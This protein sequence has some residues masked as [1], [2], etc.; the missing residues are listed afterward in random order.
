MKPADL[1]VTRF[2]GL[3]TTG[4]PLTMGLSWLTEADNI[5]VT[6][7]D[8]IE[9]RIGHAATA[10][11]AGT[12][13]SSA[14]ATRDQERAYLIDSGALKTADNVTLATGL[15]TDQA[16]WAEVNDL[17]FMANGTDAVMIDADN[18]VHQWAWPVPPSPT[19]AAVS[20]TLAAGLYRACTTYILPDGRE[21][22]PSEMVEIELIEGQALQVSGIPQVSGYITRTYICPANSTVFGLARS[23]SVTAFSW[24]HPPTSLGLELRTEGCDPIPAGCDVIQHWQGRIWA[25]LY[26]P[27][28]DTTAIFPSKP[29]GFHL[30]D[31]DEA[32]AVTGCVLMLAPTDAGL[33]IGTNKHI[34][35]RL[36]DGQLTRIAHYGVVPGSPWAFD[37]LEDGRDSDKTVLIWS[38]RGL[39]RA[40]PFANLT[41]GHLSVAP[42]VEASAAV[43][44]RSGEKH[45]IANLH[46]GG[47]AF[48]SR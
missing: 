29:L 23:G 31:L 14:Y 48:N 1:Q 25:A 8:K 36:T 22:G 18:A 7:D 13:I 20:G 12:A 39:C 41:A 17:V 44:A 21:T 47:S 46:A 6:G 3:N 42:G 27:S 38:Q 2:R 16:H 9:R 10:T 35:A 15:S 26:D 4:D 43:I 32:V 37:L 5:N 40:L 19:L 34:W 30:F 24:D 45:F 28:S 11:V 33:V